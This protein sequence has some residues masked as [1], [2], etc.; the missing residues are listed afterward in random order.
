MVAAAGEG[1][2][3]VVLV[4]CGTPNRGMGWYHA[5]QMI[6]GKCPSAKLCF[7]VE[8]WFLGA[9]TFVFW[10]G[11]PCLAW[12]EGWLLSAL[13]QRGFVWRDQLQGFS[14]HHACVSHANLFLSFPTPILKQAPVDQ[15]DQNLLLGP[16]RLKKRKESNSSSPSL[17]FLLSPKERT[18]LL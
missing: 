3:E 9:G 11:L 17:T 2:C 7:V 6:K 13:M 5:V 4:G 12:R 16:R 15:E 18:V 14:Y 1:Q 10:R 8:P